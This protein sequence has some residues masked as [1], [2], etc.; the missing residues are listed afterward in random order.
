MGL[1]REQ[2]VEY[3]TRYVPGNEIVDFPLENDVFCFLEMPLDSPAGDESNWSFAGYNICL[4][5]S[6]DLDSKPQGKWIWMKYISLTTFPP[7]ENVLRLQPPHVAKGL[8]QDEQRT[9]AIRIVK[10]DTK[11][12][13]GEVRQSESTQDNGEGKIL[14]FPL[15]KQ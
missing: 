13:L 4:E 8:F 1:T 2:I 7:H 15:K 9:K 11:K 6:P 10:V 14:K 3:A 5:Y 12:I